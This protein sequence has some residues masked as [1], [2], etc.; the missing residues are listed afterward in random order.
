M[1]NSRNSI[2]TKEEAINYYKSKRVRVKLV[3]GQVD[4]IEFYSMKNFDIHD[5]ELLRFFPEIGAVFIQRK[6]LS[7]EG[8]VYLKGL[9]NITSLDFSG[10]SV[11]GEGVK[12]LIAYKKINF[13]NVENTLFD[14]KGLQYLSDLNFSEPLELN[15]HNTKITDEG[16]KYLSKIKLTGALY[17]ANTKITDEGLKY[18]ANQK[19]LAEID[20]R[21]TK[22]TKAG[23]QWL[24]KQLP[25]TGIQYGKYVIQRD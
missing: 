12:H 20:L 5:L 21:G 13:L 17:L 10:S 4:L 9:K 8:L 16:L 15:L 7:D 3:N 11:K 18:L 6:E 14:D 1:K 25:N 22:I 19:D 23:A 24:E 2:S